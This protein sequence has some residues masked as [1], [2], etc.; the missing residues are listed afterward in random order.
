M[1]CSES[2]LAVERHVELPAGP[3][4]VWDALPEMLGDEV[5]LTAEPGGA[6]RTHGPDGDRIGV[7]VEAVPGERLTFQWMPVDGD[8][9][10]SEVE[11]TLEPSG[12]GTILHVRETRLDGANLERAAFSARARV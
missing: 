11:I 6:L 5:E 2:D 8:A 12:V 3:H 9:A 4:E 10:P 1:S 7:V